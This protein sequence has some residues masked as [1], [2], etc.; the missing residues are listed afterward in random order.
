MSKR[1]LSFL[2]ILGAFLMSLSVFIMP[3]GI[4]SVAFLSIFL[5]A[6]GGIF[7]GIF[8]YEAAKK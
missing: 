2:G 8:S 1:G 6:M 3:Y 4:E 5:A 7:F